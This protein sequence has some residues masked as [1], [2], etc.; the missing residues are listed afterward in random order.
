MSRES[1]VLAAISE[2]RYSSGQAISKQL[3]ISRSAVWK[4]V[5]KLRAQGYVIEASPRNGYRM[6]RRP[7][8]LLPAE[9]M[10]LLQTKVVGSRIVH[11][12]RVDSTAD[13]ARR[14]IDEAAPE[15]TVVIAETQTQGRGRLGRPWQTPLGEALALSVILYPDLPPVRT[16]L[17]SLATALAIKKAVDPVIR[18]VTGASTNVSLKW[19]NDIYLGGRK[20]AG[21]LVEMAADMDRV[22]WVILS[23]GL[24]VNNSLTGSGLAARATSL[25]TEF[26]RAFSRREL[27]AAIL[28]ELDRVY[29]LSR[30]DRGL[31]GIRREFEQLDILQGNR[32]QVT[33]PGGIVSGIVSGI[34]PEG[35]LLVRHPDGRVEA[36]FSGEATLA[37][38]AAAL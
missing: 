8:R 25:K 22:K 9:V 1:D 37:G 21:V 17:L 38:D 18:T 20:L 14:L 6:V 5:V 32:V 36:L 11:E 26:G 29:D 28:G 13:A 2:D 35:R 10:P 27:L 15:G 33:T 23:L 16:P 12:D 24:N 4:H 7:D 19:P 3:N 31:D 30:T 34:D